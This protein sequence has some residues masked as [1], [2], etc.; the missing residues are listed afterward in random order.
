M[1]EELPRPGSHGRARNRIQ[2][3]VK[4]LWPRRTTR[5]R[6]LLIALLVLAL[7]AALFFFSGSDS[8]EPYISPYPDVSLPVF[9]GNERDYTKEAYVT[10]LAPSDPHPCTEGEP[11]YYFEACKVTIHR[12][13]RNTTTRDPFNRPFIVLVTANVPRN[14][15][16]VLES[17]GAIVKPVAT[18]SHI[19]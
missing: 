1:K 11:D 12:L 16:D 6:I 15:I 4:R 7:M 3:I 14:Q 10:L 17:H 5:V 19:G 2:P 8:E 9:S 18:N 13:R